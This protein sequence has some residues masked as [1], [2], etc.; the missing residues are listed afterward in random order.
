MVKKTLLTHGDAD[1]SGSAGLLSNEV[2]MHPDTVEVIR[3]ANRAY[4]SESEG[5]V[6][7]EI[8]TK[9]INLFSDFSVCET[10]RTFPCSA[11]DLQ[12]QD[13]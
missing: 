9:L 11:I 8:Y 3:Q 6:L 10:P 4:G 5:S 7:E 13:N 1:H 2:W 12:R